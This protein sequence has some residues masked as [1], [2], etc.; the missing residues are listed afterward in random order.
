MSLHNANTDHIFTIM[1]FGGKGCLYIYIQV[2]N[3]LLQHQV[4]TMYSTRWT[5]QLIDYINMEEMITMVMV[6]MSKIW[7]IFFSLFK[8][9]IDINMYGIIFHQVYIFNL[10]S[11]NMHE[12]AELDYK[13]CSWSYKTTDYYYKQGTLYN[14]WWQ[15]WHEMTK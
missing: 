3:M 15:K 5:L 13:N 4:Y 10:F 2:Y 7:S 11:I 8:I 6:Y 1:F 14:R 12:N 9:Y